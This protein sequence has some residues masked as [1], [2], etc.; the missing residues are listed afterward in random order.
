MHELTVTAMLIAERGPDVA[1]RYTAHVGADSIKAAR[2][3]QRFATVLQHRPIPCA[4]PE[5]LDA[6]A[7]DLERKYGKPFFNDYGW[8]ADTLRNPNRP[9]PALRL[10]ST[11]IACGRISN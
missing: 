4:R 8:A 1:E 2:Q 9:L 10:R 5:G 11:L 3:Y 6:L 7:V